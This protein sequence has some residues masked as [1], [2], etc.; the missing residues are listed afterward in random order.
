M[1]LTLLETQFQ[2]WKGC[3]LSEKANPVFG[4]GHFSASVMFI[5]EAPGE[6][7]DKLGRP[8]VGAAGKFLDELLS[9]INLKREDVYITNV[10]KYR[11]PANRDPTDLEKDQCMPWLKLQIALIK[12]H[13][14]VPLGRHALGHFLSKVTISNAHGKAHRLTDS[15]TVFP[16]YHPA[17]ALH[18]GG[19]RQAL[20]DDFKALGEFLKTVN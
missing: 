8:F 9:S 10:V 2:T 15:V 11:P 5:G 4:E 14:I 17:A 6:Q 19:L 1:D 3:P 12:P 16:I 18:N 7:E 20:Y 13:V